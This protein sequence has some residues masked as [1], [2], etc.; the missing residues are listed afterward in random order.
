KG[1]ASLSIV[2]GQLLHSAFKLTVNTLSFLRIGA[3][4]LGHAALSAAVIA[5]ASS[6][7]SLIAYY[8]ILV[9]GQIFIIATAGLVVFIQT[10]RLIFF[11]FFTQFLRSE[12]RIF[13]PLSPPSASAGHGGNK[14][15]QVSDK[16]ADTSRSLS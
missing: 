1:H 9:G 3:F 13:K 11:E 15:A 7:E 8:L 5:I 4:A 2:T 14:S 10:T 16:I 6:T 12:G